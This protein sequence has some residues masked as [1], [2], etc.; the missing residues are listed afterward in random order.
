MH[1]KKGITASGK[2][3]WMVLD[4]DYSPIAPI[5]DYLRYLEN[6]EKS[7]NTIKAYARNL[8]LY[9][10]FLYEHKIDWTEITILKLSV[11]A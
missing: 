8:K 10:D 3:I 11:L 1:I 9:W 7:P 4:C 2:E 5:H 6:K